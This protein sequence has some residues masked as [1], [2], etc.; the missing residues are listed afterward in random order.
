MSIEYTGIKKQTVVGEVNKFLDSCPDDTVFKMVINPKRG[1][2][3]IKI[4]HA[5]KS[6]I[7]NIFGKLR[8]RK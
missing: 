7:R 4:K 1:S 6:R 5:K 8:R 3:K 2:V